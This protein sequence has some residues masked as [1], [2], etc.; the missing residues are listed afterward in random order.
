MKILKAR[1]EAKRI[2]NVKLGNMIIE[3]NDDLKRESKYNDADQKL[4]NDQVYNVIVNI[5]KSNK[6]N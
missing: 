4:I 2:I 1:K 3:I 6:E 5:I